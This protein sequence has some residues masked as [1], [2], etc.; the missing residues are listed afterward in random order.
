MGCKTMQEGAPMG[1]EFVNVNIVAGMCFIG[2]VGF[3]RKWLKWILMDTV[4]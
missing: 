3:K 1:L 4:V 2:F